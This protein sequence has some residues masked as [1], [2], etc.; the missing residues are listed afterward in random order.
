MLHL[1]KISY[2]DSEAFPHADSPNLTVT[3]VAEAFLKRE[4]RLW[5]EDGSRAQGQLQPSQAPTVER[6]LDQQ[7]TEGSRQRLAVYSWSGEGRWSCAEQKLG[8][9][10][11]RAL[12]FS[13]L[14]SWRP[15]QAPVLLDI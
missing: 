14:E 11:F 13:R 9:V 5:A 15:C 3:H 10:A 8:I 2:A 1:L 7:E 6:E 4:I 12:D